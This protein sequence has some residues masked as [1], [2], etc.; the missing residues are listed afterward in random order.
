M[1]GIDW[2][3]RVTTAILSLSKTEVVKRLTI[4]VRTSQGAG[5][6]GRAC[7][8]PSK[9]PKWWLQELEVA[10]PDGEVTKSLPFASQ[11][12]QYWAVERARITLLLYEYQRTVKEARKNG[13]PTKSKAG[14]LMKVQQNEPEIEKVVDDSEADVINADVSPDKEQVDEAKLR[15]KPTLMVI[16]DD[17]IGNSQHKEMEAEIAALRKRVREE[18]A[19]WRKECEE[20][21]QVM[22]NQNK[23]DVEKLKVQFKLYRMKN[24]PPRVA[25][26]KVS[27]YV[28][29]CGADSKEHLMKHIENKVQQIHADN[30]LEEPNKSPQAPL[31][32]FNQARRDE[33]TATVKKAARNARKRNKQNATPGA[34]LTRLRPV[35]SSALK[36]TK[37]NRAILRGVAAPENAPVAVVE[38][39]PMPQAESNMKTPPPVTRNGRL[40]KLTLREQ[41][42][43]ATMIETVRNLPEESKAKFI[44]EQK[45]ATR[46]RVEKLREL[47]EAQARAAAATKA[48]LAEELNEF[49]SWDRM[50][51]Q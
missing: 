48:K 46:A 38:T 39:V 35:R 19:L 28:K 26:M 37:K 7:W 11:S 15:D 25:R 3:S 29:D 42:K 45:D 12:K 23:T 18:R 22:I 30:D 13:S 20:Q 44:A 16:H 49:E 14:S 34:T 5:V 47:A 10:S 27:D 32:T 8:A 41:D 2:N 9:C 17:E 1:E 6:K 24:L 4:A 36:A 40:A 50:G 31:T 43:L 21:H 51:F 33:V